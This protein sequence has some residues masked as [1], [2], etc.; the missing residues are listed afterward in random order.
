[1]RECCRRAVLTS[2]LAQEPFDAERHRRARR[3]QHLH[4]NVT[5][6]RPGPAGEVHGCHTATT[7]L[8]LDPIAVSQ[9]RL[10]TIE[11]LQARVHSQCGDPRAAQGGRG[12]RAGEAQNRL[13]R[14]KS[15]ERTPGK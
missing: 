10:Q 13:H 1:M 4:R 6:E 11:K 15:G 9:C 14:L 5:V 2:D 3:K 12:G 7:E 8:S